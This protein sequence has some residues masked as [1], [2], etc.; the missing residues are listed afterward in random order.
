MKYSG[1]KIWNSIDESI[2]NSKKTKFQEIENDKYFFLQ[3]QMFVFVVEG[4]LSLFW[5]MFLDIFH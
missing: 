3:S 1:V 2:R 5:G 4:C